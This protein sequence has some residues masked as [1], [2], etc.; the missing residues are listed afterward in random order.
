MLLAN[1][2]WK[3]SH[4]PVLIKVPYDIP[5][6]QWLMFAF[7]YFY[8]RRLTIQTLLVTFPPCFPPRS[9]H[10]HQGKLK[11]AARICYLAL[12]RSLCWGHVTQKRHSPRQ[13]P[14]QAT[15]TAWHLSLQ[16]KGLTSSV[17]CSIH[18]R[19]SERPWQHSQ[20]THPNRRGTPRTSCSA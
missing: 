20:R 17:R 6:P 3:S 8:V 1:N 19:C 14:L 12:W 15:A 18:T 4:E 9:T 16:P 13:L 7:M 10:Y 2:R 11:T 5:R